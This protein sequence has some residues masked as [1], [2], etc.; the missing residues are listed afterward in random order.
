MSILYT[1]G[2][3]IKA[4]NGTDTGEKRKR[5]YITTEAARPP[6]QTII[7]G[8]SY[9]PD[10]DPR[11][12]PRNWEETWMGFGPSKY[13]GDDVVSAKYGAG[14]LEFI[15]N[16]MAMLKAARALKAA[17]YAKG[18]KDESRLLKKAP[19][20]V[21]VLK[22][23]KDAKGGVMIP[24]T[25]LG[26]T[27]NVVHQQEPIRRIVKHP[28]TGAEIIQQYDKVN[29][30]WMQLPNYM[31]KPDPYRGI[32]GASTEYNI[33]TKKMTGGKDYFSRGSIKEHNEFKEG[34]ILYKL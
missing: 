7:N 23:A 13:T 15:S 1:N 30:E 5:E 20:V 28:F 2:K 10:E 19:R 31:A 3:V 21:K 27:G 16:P 34:G 18:I 32:Y 17:E 4:Q 33:N 29:N 8:R 11:A 6:L 12:D 24:T 25:K 26:F 9:G 22:H 14:M